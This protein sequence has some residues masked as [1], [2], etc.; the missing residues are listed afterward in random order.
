MTTTDLAQAR[1]QS[2]PPPD[3][4][5]AVG[6]SVAGLL[7]PYRW[8]FAAQDLLRQ[9][10]D[11]LP[12]RC[13]GD[14]A[15]RPFGHEFDGVMFGLVVETFEGTEHAELYPD[16]LGFHEPWDGSYDT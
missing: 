7:R 2:T 8:S 11:A 16:T 6:Q 12:G 15:I 9:W 10:L 13:Y 5:S 3:A 1:E 14:I 4:E